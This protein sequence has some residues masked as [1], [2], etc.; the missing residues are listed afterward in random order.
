MG[1]N[2]PI[3]SAVPTCHHL[4][5]PVGAR[6]GWV[7]HL[8]HF[9]QLVFRWFSA[10]PSP[11]RSARSRRRSHARSAGMISP[12]H[13]IPPVPLGCCD[14]PLGRDEKAPDLIL[15]RGFAKH[16]NRL[17]MGCRMGKFSINYEETRSS[18]FNSLCPLR[19]ISPS[20]P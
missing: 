6:F 1:H 18:Y 7:R 2:D 16:G 11:Q 8:S 13:E 4:K 3:E 12:Y 15:L 5:R 10:S 19:A 17:R 14:V 20:A 9:V